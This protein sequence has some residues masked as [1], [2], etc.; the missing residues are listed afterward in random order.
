MTIERLGGYPEDKSLDL[1]DFFEPEVRV[2]IAS[3]L[4]I[5]LVTAPNSAIGGRTD[6][7]LRSFKNSSVIEVYPPD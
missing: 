2:E 6:I 7:S 1:L 4:L 3:G 5:G